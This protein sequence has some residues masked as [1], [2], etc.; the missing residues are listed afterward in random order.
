VTGALIAHVRD[1]LAPLPGI[2]ARRMFGGV[3]LFRDGAMFAIVVDD[4][5]YLKADAE[6]APLF[7]AVGARPF[8]YRR[9]GRTVALSYREAPAE[10]I[11]DREALAPW[12]EAAFA[13]ALRARR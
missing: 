5:L 3:G 9:R 11:E 4:T 8:T 13:A 2:A 6:S 10:A 1:L 7:D 12:A